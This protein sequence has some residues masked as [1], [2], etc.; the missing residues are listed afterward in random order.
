MLVAEV[1]LARKYRLLHLSCFPSVCI[2]NLLPIN[3]TSVQVFIVGGWVAAFK[4]VE[5]LL[6]ELRI[7]EGMK[8]FSLLCQPFRLLELSLLWLSLDN[9][10]IFLRFFIGFLDGLIDFLTLLGFKVWN[11]LRILL[12]RFFVVLALI[13]GALWLRSFGIF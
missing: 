12:L 3:L 11:V 13:F 1:V 7:V 8:R 10:L 5:L 4:L 2:G 6:F 9:S